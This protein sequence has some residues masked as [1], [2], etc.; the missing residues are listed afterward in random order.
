M[1]DIRRVRDDP[2][3]V[4]ADLRKRGLTVKVPWVDEV[5]LF[6]AQWRRQLT[7]LNEL[8]RI[9]NRLTEEVAVLKK[10]GS[11]FTT[12]IE[13]AEKI[14]SRINSLRR[15]VRDTRERVDYLL[16]RL[17]NVMHRTVPLGKDEAEN[18]EIRRCGTIPNLT[19]QPKDHIDISLDLDLVDLKRAA[20]VAGSRFYYLKNDLV[21]L[22][23]A[24]IH[25]GLDFAQER[26][27]TL[28]QPPYAITRKAMDGAVS[29]S[30]FEEMLYKLEGED[31]YLIATSEHAMVAL[32]M[33]ELLD[34]SCLPLRYC[35]VSPNFRKEAGAHG[36]DT[37][38][39]FRTHQFEKV[40]QVVFCTPDT[41][42]DE[43][44]ALIRNAEQFLQ[45]LNLPYR[46]VNV[47][48]GD[49][50]TVA[51]KKYDIEVWLPGQ[52]RYREIVSCS[53]CTAYQAVRS[54]IRYRS[55]PNDPTAYVH[56][57]NST[58][59]A[60]ERCIIA[61]LENYQRDDGSVAIPKVLV[62]YMN[63]QERIVSPSLS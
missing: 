21:L 59:V 48:S 38:G 3:I 36:R 42:W 23:H 56:T 9:R 31:L 43:H 16:M 13:E 50:G 32:H 53:N 57:L 26:M 51:A 34:G 8:R 27:F 5:L 61:I 14:V 6:D 7:A 47:C 1:L 4:R 28:L 20:K 35:G 25:Y 44:E 39:I 52:N 60:T 54:R 22:N 30:D 19:F 55:N 40:E 29:L 33:D 17:P 63:G 49:L 11:D 62:P 12:N 41:S 15:D 37:K 24:L 18:V 2:E 45:N 46:V 10:K 58:L